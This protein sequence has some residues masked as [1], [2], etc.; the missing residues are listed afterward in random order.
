MKKISLLIVVLA[1]IVFASFSQTPYEKGMT[2][3]LQMWQDKQATEAIALFERI[4]SVE[5][6]NWLPNYYIGLISATQVL[7]GREK[8]NASSLLEQA[9]KNLDK[10]E[11]IS[12]NNSEIFCLQ[13]LINTAWVTLDYMNNGQK[14][15]PIIIESY[16][17]AIR[18]D[19][20]NPRPVYLLA[21]YQINLAKMFGQDTKP[22]YN[23]IEASLKK[24]D[25]FK[26]PSAF[27]PLWGAERASSLLKA[28]NAN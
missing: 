4:A 18:L 5:K 27:H 21:Q 6:E 25:N 20:N 26:A 10:A 16:Q 9:Q 28:Q 23:R 24:F 1:S 7:S 12:N 11:N 19:P 22:F 13:G 8:E 2:K 14:L 3:A 17:N 15:S